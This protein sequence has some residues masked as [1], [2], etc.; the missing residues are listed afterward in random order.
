[1]AKLLEIG[2][3]YMK[4]FQSSVRWAVKKESTECYKLDL[5]SCA[6]SSDPVLPQSSRGSPESYFSPAQIPWR[7][8]L[9]LEWIP[10]SFHSLQDMVCIN[11]SFAKQKWR[12]REQIHG[13][14][15]GKGRRVG[16]IGG[17]GLTHTHYYWWKSERDSRSVVSDSL[18]PCEL[19]PAKLLCPWNSPGK[20]T[21][22]GSHSLL[23]RIFPI[24]V[25]NP[26][27]MHCRKI[28]YRLS[29]REAI[30]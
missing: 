12:H 15:G 1:M 16:G 5:G 2:W 19:W 11:D 23:Q 9:H 29:T 13:Y 28:L 7:L 20:N 4:Q 24:Q 14:Q 30:K 8:A 10:N 27:F 6:S 18:R 17:L 25:S 3:G 21:G 22:V 26:G